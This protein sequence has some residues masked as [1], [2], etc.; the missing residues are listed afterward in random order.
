MQ[1]NNKYI[2]KKT[3]CVLLPALLMLEHPDSVGRFIAVL[4]N[5]EV[6]QS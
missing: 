3:Q 4:C 2:V 5:A 1:A 6:K